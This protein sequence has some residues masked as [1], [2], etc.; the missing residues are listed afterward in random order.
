MEAVEIYR[1]LRHPKLG[2]ALQ[3]VG[4]VYNGR[5]Q[6]HP[7]FEWGSS[8]GPQ[9]GPDGDMAIEQYQQA[10]AAYEQAGTQVGR[11]VLRGNRPS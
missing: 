4:T 2:N 6:S 9:H 3:S 7:D 8:T 11:I 5:Y 10:L 1:R